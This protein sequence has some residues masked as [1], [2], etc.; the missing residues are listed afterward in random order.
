MRVLYHGPTAT[1]S[2][3]MLKLAHQFAPNPVWPC[4]CILFW[5]SCTFQR[6][7]KAKKGTPPSALQAHL[8]RWNFLHLWTVLSADPAEAFTA[9][10]QWAHIPVPRGWRSPELLHQHEL[11]TLCQPSVTGPPPYILG[12]W[13]GHHRVM[14]DY[15][16]LAWYTIQ[17]LYSFIH[18]R[19]SKND[20]KTEVFSRAFA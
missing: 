20:E 7:A 10:I 1:T 2:V 11:N 6:R 8:L 15:E 13:T 18:E 3:S 9:Y 12:K 14:S 5:C 16:R 19:I 4:V 17:E